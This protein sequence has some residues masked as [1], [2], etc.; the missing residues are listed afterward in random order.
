MRYLMRH[1]I[2]LLGAMLWSAPPALVSAPVPATDLPR[3][4][5]AVFADREW[6]E[7]WRSERAPARWDA[8]LPVVADAVSWRP[9]AEEG[10]EWGELRLSGTGEAWRLR[11]ILARLDPT[12]FH[13]RLEQS[14]REDRLAGAWSVD[15]APD[16]AVLA[17]NAG[18]F[19]YGTPWG[20]VVRRGEEERPPGSGPL[21]MAVLVDSIGAVTFVPTDSLPLAPDGVRAV[22]AF[23]SYPSL[24]VDDGWVPDPLLDEGRGIDVAHRDTRLAIGELRDGRILIALTRFDGLGG[25]LSVVPFGPTV[26]EM[27]A[28]MGALGCRRAVMLD[29]GISGQLMVRDEEGEVRAW[30]GLRRVPLGLVVVKR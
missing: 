4:S 16:D 11:V 6:R 29:G 26:P 17:V 25:V 2:P 5:L 1:Y 9:A 15:D 28:L 18:Q 12:R 8:S 20:W 23:Q 21:S 19:A 22:E 30:R 13:L 24:L 27:A 7:W 10:M 14:I 3:S